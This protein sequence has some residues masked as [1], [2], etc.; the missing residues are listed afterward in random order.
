MIVF[1]VRFGFP[2]TQV[3]I[4]LLDSSLYHLLDSSLDTKLSDI[5]LKIS[6]KTAVTVVLAAEG[7]P[8]SYNKGMKIDGL[9]QIDKELVFHAGT[10]LIEGEIV[11][12]GGRVLNVIGFGENLQSAIEEAYKISD[13]IN[14]NDK[15][16]RRD[17]GQ[18][19]LSYK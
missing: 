10:K 13:K 16:L 6:S 1:Y 19:G 18:K 2:E 11:T 14:F 8:E 12:S 4:P 5:N 15:F 7:Y 17:I 9:D 3:V